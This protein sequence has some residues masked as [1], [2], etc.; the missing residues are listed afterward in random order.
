M[1][2]DRP[3]PLPSGTRIHDYRLERTIG[4]GGFGITYLAVDGKRAREV[5]IKEYCPGDQAA[6][7]DDGTISPLPGQEDNFRAG[8]EGFAAL[9]RSLSAIEHPSIV[10]VLDT[11]RIAG[12][13]FLVME[14]HPGLDL[15]RLLRQRRRLTVGEVKSILFPLM[16]HC[17]VKPANIRL[18]RDGTPVLVDFGAARSPTAGAPSAGTSIHSPNYSPIE[19]HAGP[20]AAGPWTDI[21]SLAATVYHCLFA[22]PPPDAE[23]RIQTDGLDPASER[24][25]NMA[26]KDFLK[27]LDTG[28][29]LRPEARPRTVGDWQALFGFDRAGDPIV[30]PSEDTLDDEAEWDDDYDE[31]EDVTA[32]K[33]VSPA[34]MEFLAQPL[35]KSPARS[36]GK[37]AAVLVVLLAVVGAFGGW[38]WMSLEQENKA[39]RNAGAEGSVAAYRAFLEAWPKGAHAMAA[40]AEIDRLK[41]EEGIPD[42]QKADDAAFAAARDQGTVDSYRAYMAAWP[43]GHHAETARQ[44][45]ERLDAAEEEKKRKQQ[46]LEALRLAKEKKRKA[47]EAKARHLAEEDNRKAEAEAARLAAEKKEAEAIRLAEEKKKKA[48]AIRLAEEKKKAEAARLAE[49]RKR[50]AEAARLAEE[51]K[52]KAE[53]ARL[54]EKRK[55]AEAEAARLAEEKKRQAEAR[56]LAEQRKGKAVALHSMPVVPMNKVLRVLETTAVHQGASGAT[57]Q[58]AQLHQGTRVT[59]TGRTRSGEW[60]RISDMG[61]NFGFVRSSAFSPKTAVPPKPPKET[62]REP[63]VAAAHPAPAAPPAGK[64]VGTVE[65]INTQWGFVVIDLA[66]DHGLRRGNRVFVKGDG[67]R[68]AWLRIEKV[69]PT[70]GSAS[71][72]DKGTMVPPAAKVFKE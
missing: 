48:D 19:L 4:Q 16:V 15:S 56:R 34:A 13:A 31:M 8:L 23:A 32:R 14:Y 64:Q 70:K 38:R 40:R 50:K 42:D 67:G 59:V 45:I 41:A 5:A 49:E 37:V 55:K 26:E 66:P 35:P 28:L 58:L 44:E 21:Y 20:G 39:W 1:A 62:A 68:R 52:K 36:R 27:A 46:V 51:K 53:A 57:P 54:A 9:A 12:T 25:Y 10:R 24:G 18:H 29:V 71:I 47:D 22:E 30:L 43:S 33:P 17:D 63:A 65:S 61:R 11:F 2:V 72:V 69:A 7:R 3:T 6:R 60:L